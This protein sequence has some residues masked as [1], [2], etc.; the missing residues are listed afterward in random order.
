M[1]PCSILFLCIENSNRSQMAEAF[2]KIHGAHIVNALSAGSAPSGKI[3]PAAV[4]AMKQKG[5]DLAA[6]KS[7][8][9][10]EFRAVSFDYV[11][12]MGC[13]DECPFIPAKYHEDWDIPD[14]KEMN[15]KEFFIVR[16]S[17]ETKVIGLIEKIKLEN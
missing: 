3:N 4:E 7:K 2:A 14:P 11:I 12:T 5:Y 13:G 6:H 8:S 16:D 10:D 15:L 17:I 9:A 1:P